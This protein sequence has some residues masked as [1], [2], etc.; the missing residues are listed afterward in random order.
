MNQRKAYLLTYP[1]V[2]QGTADVQACRLL[3]NPKV[4]AAR[5]EYLESQWGEKEKVI[6][7][8]FHKLKKISSADISEFIDESGNIKVED[9]KCLDTFAVAQYDQAVSDTKEGQNVRQSI[10]MMD[11]QKAIDTLA[12]I[13]GMIQ[14]KVEHTGEIIVLPAERPKDED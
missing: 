5:Q 3:S 12:K 1:G 9:F 4:S 7:E 8:L 6:A 14:D 11:K 10:K 2:K 13:L